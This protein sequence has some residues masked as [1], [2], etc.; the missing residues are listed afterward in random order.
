M[1][2]VKRNITRIANYI[3]S[4]LAV[5]F[6]EFCNIMSIESKTSLVILEKYTLPSVIFR[7]SPSDLVGNARKNGNYKFSKERA[8]RLIKVSFESIGIP[9]P[10][11]AYTF[12]IRIHA[13]MLRSDIYYLKETENKIEENGH[14]NTDIRNRSDIMGMSV[15]VAARIVFEIGSIDQFDSALKLDS[16]A[17]R[18]PGVT[19][20]GGNHTPVD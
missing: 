13:K 9:D 4:D 20:R 18:C 3:N 5:V 2:I 8:E 17:K 12:R 7:H 19:G 6:P 11:G 10:D 16:F 1:E 15:V 14:G